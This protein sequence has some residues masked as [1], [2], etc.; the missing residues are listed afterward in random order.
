MMSF[1]QMIVQQASCHAPKL[2]EAPG[3]G[4]A[5][6]THGLLGV[7]MNAAPGVD[8]VVPGAYVETVTGEASLVG[9]GSEVMKAV[10]LQDARCAAKHAAM[11]ARRGSGG[12]VASSAAGVE[13]MRVEVAGPAGRR[14][15]TIPVQAMWLSRRSQ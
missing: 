4:S 8:G 10:D 13:V 9:L 7:R 15:L 14:S 12:R 11:V 3:W 5:G 2:H 1:L 6:D